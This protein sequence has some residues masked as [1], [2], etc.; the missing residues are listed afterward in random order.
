MNAVAIESVSEARN[1]ASE[2]T[3]VWGFYSN[4]SMLR[5][6]K[7]SS[8][9]EAWKRVAELMQLVGHQYVGGPAIQPAVL[10]VYAT[11]PGTHGYSVKFYR[12]NAPQFAGPEGMAGWSAQTPFISSGVYCG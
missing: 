1:A 6:E 12:S 9:K 7:F 10:E 3:I 2:F 11:V 8:R 5:H 4:T